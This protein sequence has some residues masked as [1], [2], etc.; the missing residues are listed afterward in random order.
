VTTK[1]IEF[2]FNPQEQRLY[3]RDGRVYTASVG[4][5]FERTAGKEEG[6][7]LT[8]VLVERPH[9]PGAP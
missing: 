8:F 7:K 6:E 1:R 4:A 3:F 9:P 2:W 5:V